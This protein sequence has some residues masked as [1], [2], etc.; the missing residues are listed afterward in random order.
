MNT[1]TRNDV[2]ASIDAMNEVVQESELSVLCSLVDQMDKASVILESYSGDAIDAFAI[3]QEADEASSVQQGDPS[4]DANA[5]AK[6]KNIFVKIWEFIKNVVKSIGSYIKKCWNGAVI[7]KV[8]TVT[9]KAGDIIDKITGKDE[10]WIRNNAVAIGIGSASV[11][12]ACIG[13]VTLNKEINEPI[14]NLKK[15]LAGL[16]LTMTAAIGE[17]AGSAWVF[18]K[19][20]AKTNIAIPILCGAITSI[21]GIITALKSKK[22]FDAVIA[23]A[24]LL[25]TGED[26]NPSVRGIFLDSMKEYSFDEIT[27]NLSETQKKLAGITE[28]AFILPT[29]E[30]NDD[31]KKKGEEAA[32]KMNIFQK[33]ILAAQGLINKIID[34]L[35]KVKG[36][37]KT[38]REGA[39]DESGSGEGASGEDSSDQNDANDQNP[40]GDTENVGDNESSDTPESTENQSDVADV[41]DGSGSDETNADETSTETF[42]QT[43]LTKGQKLTTDE[44]EKILKQLGVI[45][46]DKHLNEKITYRP[47]SSTNK[48]VFTD[49]NN[50]Q[51]KGLKKV[52]TDDNTIAWVVEYS[53]EEISEDE[54]VVTESHSPYYW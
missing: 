39:S 54:D 49:S 17:I 50:Q 45:G 4:G 6:K 38:I 48:K 25:V 28:D 32:K 41:G 2:L 26:K 29:P 44:A 20:G 36:Y 3:Y 7:P 11:L 21:L 42:D 19:S 8:E 12:A 31:D 5:E 33:I 46:D 15:I 35:D 27:M 37:F 9:D 40:T 43:S 51:Y 52:R 53:D 47:L 16:G 10:S 18:T 30:E 34:C 13:F 24:D 14:A 1:T 23:G 22:K